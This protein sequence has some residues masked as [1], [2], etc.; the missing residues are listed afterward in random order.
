[1]LYKVKLFHETS[2]KGF[3]EARSYIRLTFRNSLLDTKT[4]QWDL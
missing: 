4:K 1:M 3:R 2:I